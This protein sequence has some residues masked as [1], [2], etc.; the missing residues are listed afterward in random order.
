MTRIGVTA[1]P[2]R[3]R[4]LLTDGPIGARILSSTERGARIGLVAQTALLLGGDHIEIEIDIGP[5]AWL[6][7]VETAGTVVYDAEG[8]ASSWI[9]R[10]RVAEGGRLIWAGEPFVVASGANVRRE[11]VIELGTDAVA[12]LRETLVLGRTGETGGA[13]SSSMRVTHEGRLLLWE[14]LDLTDQELRS[15]PGVTGST[16]VL[17]TMALFGRRAPAGPELPAGCRFDLDGPGTV[18]RSLTAGL[19]GSVL[20]Q[21]KAAWEAEVNA[22]TVLAATTP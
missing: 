7:L 8:V 1:A 20:S 15:L 22:A 3:A 13:I 19:A 18:A 12:L 21:V 11:T 6:E 2:G 17:D 4:L 9:V 14:D 10:I 16:R 5:G